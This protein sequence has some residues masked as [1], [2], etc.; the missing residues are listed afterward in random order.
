MFRLIFLHW[1][2]NYT[3]GRK[4]IQVV[5]RFR[6]SI[7]GKKRIKSLNQLECA[8]FYVNALESFATL[9]FAVILC[10]VALSRWEL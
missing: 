6:C 9:L 5:R 8:R 3:V 2:F 10:R 7:F 1:Y 4:E